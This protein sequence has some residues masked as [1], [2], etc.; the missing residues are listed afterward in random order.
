VLAVAHIC[1]WGGRCV[2]S[3]LAAGALPEGKSV[4]HDD[5][6]GADE[7]IAGSVGEL[8]PRVGCSN[9]DARGQLGLDGLDLTGELLASEVSAVER[10]GT[11]GDG[12]DGIGVLLGNVG[13]GLEVLVERLLNIWPVV[14]IR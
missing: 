11:D 10:L 1:D 7:G 2:R 4:H 3:V 9:L 12:V 13:D 6:S 8:V 5:V 14:Q